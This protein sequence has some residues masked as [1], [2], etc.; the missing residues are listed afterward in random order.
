M[1]PW[2]VAG[3]TESSTRPGIRVAWWQRRDV[4]TGQSGSPNDTNGV[5]NNC[6]NQCM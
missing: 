6:F 1:F 2:L 4:P 3:A 5:N